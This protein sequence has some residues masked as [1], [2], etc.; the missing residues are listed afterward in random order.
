[1]KLRLVFPLALLVPA[2]NYR[3]SSPQPRLPTPRADL[4]RVMDAL[5]NREQRDPPRTGAIP[6]SSRAT[7]Q[8]QL[9]S[10]P[11]QTQLSS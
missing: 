3:R 6:I 1:M 7:N 4:P 2:F 9:A 5:V 11:T 10:A 8:G